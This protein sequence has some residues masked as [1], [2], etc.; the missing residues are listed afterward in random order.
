MPNPFENEPHPD[1]PD[2][3]D[4]SELERIATEG[5]APVEQTAAERAE[6]QKVAEVDASEA[7][8]AQTQEALVLLGL[9][10]LRLGGGVTFSNVELTKRLSIGI[11]YKLYREGG[12]LRV[13]VVDPEGN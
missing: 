8:S 6:A 13:Y 9:A 3:L 1:V 12:G 5:D 11:D 7:Y 4:L 10:V 2:E